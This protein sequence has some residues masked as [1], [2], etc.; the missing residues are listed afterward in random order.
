MTLRVEGLLYMIY[1][2]IAVFVARLHPPRHAVSVVPATKEGRSCLMLLP[3][4]RRC[5]LVMG[6]GRTPHKAPSNAR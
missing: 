3:A 2:I 6:C 1:S 5:W 4:T